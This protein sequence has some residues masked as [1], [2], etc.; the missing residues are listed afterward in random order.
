MANVVPQESMAANGMKPLSEEELYVHAVDQSPS[1][2]AAFQKLYPNGLPAAYNMVYDEDG[3]PP[4]KYVEESVR[5]GFYTEPPDH[6]PAIFSTSNGIREFRRMEHIL[7]RRHVS[8]WSKNEVQTHCNSIRKVF[9]E[10]MKTMKKPVQWE[11]LYEYFDAHDLYHYGLTNLWNL[12]NNLYA[13]NKIIYGDIMSEAAVEIGRWIEKWAENSVNKEKLVAWK[14]KS[15][16]PI[17]LL[18]DPKD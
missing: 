17:V 1:T 15:T 2:R 18:L 8:L 4:R 7:P 9:W 11:C 5:M 14:S 3:G 12:V 16:V 13:E 10:Y 6:A